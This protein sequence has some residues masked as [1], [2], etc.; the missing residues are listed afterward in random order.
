[1]ASCN[2]KKSSYEKEREANIRRNTEL[3]RKLGINME[4]NRP[5]FQQR[6]EDS[7]SE[8]E[9]ETDLEWD[10]SEEVKRENKSTLKQMPFVT[11]LADHKENGEKQQTMK[12][13]LDSSDSNLNPK[14]IIDKSRVTKD[15]TFGKAKERSVHDSNVINKERDCFEDLKYIEFSSDEEISKTDDKIS[16]EDYLQKREDTQLMEEEIALVSRYIRQQKLEEKLEIQDCNESQILS[17]ERG[18]RHLKQ[19]DYTEEELTTEDCYVYCEECDD[20]H[21]GD[22]PLY[23]ELEP[24]KESEMKTNSLS[25]IPVPKQLCLRM[26]SIP[27]AGLGIFARET[28]PI[29]TRMGPYGGT[30]VKGSAD[31]FPNESEY[32]WQIKRDAGRTVWYIDGADVKRANWLRFVNCARSEEEQNLVAFQFRGRIYY[33]SYKVIRP[34]EELLVYYGDSY[35]KQLGIEEIDSKD[36]EAK[37]IK[38]FV[39]KRTFYRTQKDKPFKCQQCSCSFQHKGN[40]ITHTRIHTGINLFVCE[41]CNKKFTYKLHLTNHTRI[42]TG[43]KPY[44]CLTC[45]KR[46]NQSCNLTTHVRIHTG[47]KPYEC[48]TCKKRFNRSGSLTTHVRIHTGEKPYECRVCNKRFSYSSDRN[49]HERT[50]KS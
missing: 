22:C 15:F 46:F 18:R 29:R 13:K 24:L 17:V 2:N 36:T 44:E 5:T 1:M 26:S 27:N 50:H 7:S 49:S 16:Y 30:L 12:R 40:L 42:H 6:K 34:G 48:L 37:A 14:K 23:G 31:D 28:I 20:M 32:L 43:D 39:V 10:P 8:S 45:K 19:I 35:A 21:F 4:T 25:S 11:G 47:D 38:D 3:L 33:R 41:I 9:T